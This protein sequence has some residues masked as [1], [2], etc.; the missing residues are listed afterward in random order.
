M[1]AQKCLGISD[2]IRY[3]KLNCPRFSGTLTALNMSYLNWDNSLQH[4]TDC[5]YIYQL[6]SFYMSL[7]EN[8]ILSSNKASYIL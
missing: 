4:R 1:H 6:R 2:N 3:L 5:K 8:T 7:V